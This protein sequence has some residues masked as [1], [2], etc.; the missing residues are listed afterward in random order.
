MSRQQCCAIALTQLTLCP[1]LGQSRDR[2][3]AAFPW[4]ALLGSAAPAPLLLHPRAPLE[5]AQK[6]PLRTKARV[7][8]LL[9]HLCTSLCFSFAWSQAS[10]LLLCE[11]GKTSRW[12]SGHTLEGDEAEVPDPEPGLVVFSTERC[13]HS[14]VGIFAVCNLKASL[15]N[16]S[17][18]MID[19]EWECDLPKYSPRCPSSSSFN[20]VAP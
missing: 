1:C 17:L 15:D 8:F 5:P 6:Q 16:P 4:R 12:V 9:C 7:L 18:G 19:G 2:A 20:S 14:W 13:K 10:R 11:K 3:P